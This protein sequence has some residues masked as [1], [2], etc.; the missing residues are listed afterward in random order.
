MTQWAGTINYPIK[1]YYADIICLQEPT[2]KVTDD[3]IY[4]STKLAPHVVSHG[5]AFLSDWPHKTKQA[6][7][8]FPPKIHTHGTA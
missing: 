6:F 1:E 2:G 5:C 8:R 4:A 3:E 7:G